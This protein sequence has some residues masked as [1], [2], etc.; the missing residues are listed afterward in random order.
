MEIFATIVLDALLNH[1]RIRF[2][3]DA[4][5]VKKWL[6]PYIYIFTSPMHAYSNHS[7]DF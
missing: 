6:K 5:T 2:S 7:G 1:L 3:I 4:D